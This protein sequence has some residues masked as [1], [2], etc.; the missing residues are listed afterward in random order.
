M[1]FTKRVKNKYTGGHKDKRSSML[2][3]L[4]S[5]NNKITQTK[6]NI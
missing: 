3:N 2:L 6:Y 5:V 1:V 4:S